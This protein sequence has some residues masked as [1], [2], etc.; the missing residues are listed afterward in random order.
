MHYG[1]FSKLCAL[2]SYEIGLL[3]AE[4]ASCIMACDALLQQQENDD[5]QPQEDRL[6]INNLPEAV[7]TT[8]SLSNKRMEEEEM[9]MINNRRK[10][11]S[12]KNLPRLSQGRFFS[13]RRHITPSRRHSQ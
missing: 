6:M 2:K 3:D 13:F 9:A 8:S 12:L 1:I 7:V 11:N 4:Q 10:R 5:Q